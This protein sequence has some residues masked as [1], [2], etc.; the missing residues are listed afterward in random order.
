MRT[1]ILL[2][3]AILIFAI[4][5]LLLT[6]KELILYYHENYSSGAHAGRNRGACD[7]AGGDDVKPMC[8]D[9]DIIIEKGKFVNDMK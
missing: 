6:I 2:L 7:P 1:Q 4:V 5:N 3:T 9:F 8:S